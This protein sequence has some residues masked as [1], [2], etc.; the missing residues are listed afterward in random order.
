M[1]RAKSWVMLQ[2]HIIESLLRTRRMDF[3]NLEGISSLP[4]GKRRSKGEIRHEMVR[5]LAG[6]SLTGW[7]GTTPACAA[8]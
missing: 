1:N 5:N 7:A 4:L 2:R 8:P 6:L 3:R